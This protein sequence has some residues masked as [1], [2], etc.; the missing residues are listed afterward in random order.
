M[1]NIR[2]INSGGHHSWIIIDEETPE[3]DDFY[4][5]SPLTSP[6]FTPNNAR[7]IEN[8]PRNN[9]QNVSM[10]INNN[11]RHNI[12]IPNRSAINNNLKFNLDLLS[13]KIEKMNNK[14]TLQVVYTDLNKCHRFVRFFVYKSKNVTYKDLNKMLADFFKFDKSVVL[15]R[16]QNDDDINLNEDGDQMTRMNVI[17]REIKSDFKMLDLNSSTRMSYTLTIVY[18]HE[19]NIKMSQL[20]NSIEEL[21][22]RNNILNNVKN[23][24][25][26]MP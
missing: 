19:K 12:K 2:T 25:I 9:K 1:L 22:L 8:S 7:S 20:K 3:R 16:L 21:R 6:N 24:S 13:E 11:S 5:P 17:F 4:D 18:D 26:C 10:S 15:Y 23:K 14:K